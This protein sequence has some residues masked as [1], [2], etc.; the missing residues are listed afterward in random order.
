MGQLV[1]L[2]RGR[3]GVGG[4]GRRRRPDRRRMAQSIPREARQVGAMDRRRGLAQLSLRVGLY[5]LNSVDK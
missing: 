5:K 3:L 1:P 2:P 4:D